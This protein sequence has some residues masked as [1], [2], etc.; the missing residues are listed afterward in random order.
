MQDFVHQPYQWL[1]KGPLMNKNQETHLLRQVDRQRNAQ[2]CRGVV[3]HHLLEFL[4]LGL[5][6]LG[7]RGLGFRV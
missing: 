1:V 4:G 7:F 3:C 6:G 5:K 2:S